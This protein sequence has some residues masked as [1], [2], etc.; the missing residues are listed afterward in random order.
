M[1]K[2]LLEPRDEV[3]TGRLQSVI[4][5]ERVTDPR[6]RS[7]ESRPRDFLAS[8]Y[9]S[10]EIRRLVEGLHTRLN[11]SETETGLFL[12]EGPKGV[13]K[14]HNLV[15]PLHLINSPAE[16]Q[17]WLAGNGLTFSAPDGTRVMS[18]KFTDFPLDSLWAVIGQELGVN[19]STDQP[20]D[21]N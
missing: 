14:S 19:F 7:L 8:T 21:I 15:I 5:L 17:D 20:P 12:A 2:Q 10:G 6:R 1:L 18:R 4:D 11:S 3:L 9:V 16:C 13:G